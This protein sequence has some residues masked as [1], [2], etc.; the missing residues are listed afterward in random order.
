M[1]STKDILGSKICLYLV[2]SEHHDDAIVKIL[3]TVLVDQSI[4]VIYMTTNKPYD[5]LVKKFS[6]DGIDTERIC[7][8][9]SVSLP[10]WGRVSDTSRCL[11]VDSPSNLTDISMSL[12]KTLKNIKG[13]KFVVLDSL[14][15][16]LLYNSFELVLK[17]IHFSTTYLRSI[18][19][20]CAIVSF[21]QDTETSVVKEVSSFV[22][23]V[24]EVSKK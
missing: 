5:N 10:V 23:K 22:D 17:F 7:F 18:S 15:T 2:T 12:E 11:Y 6:Q 16:L 8:I 3:K 13:N 1:I 21:P 20:G 19:A 24:V 4:T 9:D 14:N